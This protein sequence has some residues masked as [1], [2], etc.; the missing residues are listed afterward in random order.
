[1]AKVRIAVIG[2]GNIGNLHL[3]NIPNEPKV[4]LTAVCDIVP[5]KANVAAEQH[6]VKAYLNSDKLLAD[7]V[8]DAVIIGTPHYAHTTIGI[9]AL[10][11]GHHVLVEKPI[12][13]HKADCERL[14][15]AHAAKDLIFAAMFNQR[16]DPYYQKIKALV[17][18]GELGQFLRINWIITTWFRT[19]TYYDSG[20]WRATWSG[21]GGGVLLNQ[22]PHNLDL[23]QWICGMPTKIHGFCTIGK[24]H[25]I[26]V[27]DEVT[28]YMEYPGGCTGIFVTTTGEAPGTNRFEIAGD[29]GKLV[30]ENGVITFTRNVIPAAEF[31]QTS[32][33]SFARP[34]TEVETFT[35]DNHGRQHA[36]ILENFADAILNG[37]ELIAPA[38]E[39][40]H[41][42]ELANTMLY[43]SLIGQPVDLPLDSA[44]YETKL[45][46]LI[47][48]STF[49]KESSDQTESD[50]TK[51]FN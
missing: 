28:A 36:E 21:E 7:R 16:T 19:Q 32:E 43:S 5:E 25:S 20:G 42:V 4:E 49:V 33:Q 47:A 6:G 48:T 14:I 45:Q 44:A 24:R 38:E 37:A 18:G 1:M 8:C 40:I 13:V 15:A 22:C 29:K 9:A 23:L 50:M 26:E 34:G 46:E 35:F 51:S 30:Y 10:E 11:S 27:E 12:S 39:G 31:L 2:I 41:S 17:E 3:R